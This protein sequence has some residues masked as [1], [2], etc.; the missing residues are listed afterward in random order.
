MNL[1]K[2]HAWGFPAGIVGKNPPADAGDMGSVPGPGRSHIP[3]GATKS[4]G[5]NC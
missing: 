4:M 1:I 5:H 2:N 3:P